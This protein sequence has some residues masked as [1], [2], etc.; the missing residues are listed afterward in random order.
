MSHLH[1]KDGGEWV[2]C[3]CCVEA[4]VCECDAPC[5]T[6]ALED[7]HQLLVAVLTGV[8]RV[9][10]EHE[11]LDLDKFNRDHLLLEHRVEELPDFRE[12]GIRLIPA[13]RE[14]GVE[15]ADANG[16]ADPRCH[17]GAAVGTND[18]GLGVHGLRVP[19]W[20]EEASDHPVILSVVLVVLAERGTD[21][22]EVLES[23]K[24]R[25]DFPACQ[26]V[27]TLLPVEADAVT[28]GCLPL[29]VVLVDAL[30]PVL[31]F[32]EHAE[33][34]ECGRGVADADA[35]E[36]RV[37]LKVGEDLLVERVSE[38]RKLVEDHHHRASFEPD[39]RFR[40]GISALAPGD[41]DQPSLLIALPGCIEVDD[42]A[43]RGDEL[44]R[45]ILLPADADNQ[46]VPEH[47]HVTPDTA[48]GFIERGGGEE[49]LHVAGVAGVRLVGMD[50]TDEE[51]EDAPHGEEHGLPGTGMSGDR[52]I[53]VLQRRV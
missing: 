27:R 19:I 3:T 18:F 31:R 9:H 35:L 41:E 47:L 24:S 23:Q 10:V 7:F 34:V 43:S 51:L 40:I 36:L 44:G 48:T 5:L 1:C 17:L 15:E 6:L 53:P 2:A 46:V 12:T 30:P 28:T 11:V 25:P 52:E 8:L 14:R 13:V 4:T 16:S 32:H 38:E 33:G 50:G 26:D 20:R 45:E 29:H 37:G 42:L 22:V 21:F 49:H 39:L